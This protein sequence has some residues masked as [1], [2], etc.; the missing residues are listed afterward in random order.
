MISP[1]ARLVSTMRGLSE[2][3][4]TAL[5]RALVEQCAPLMFVGLRPHVRKQIAALGAGRHDV[6]AALCEAMGR[7]LP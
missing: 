1:D 6:V 2:T 3:E 5:Y 7:R 4:R